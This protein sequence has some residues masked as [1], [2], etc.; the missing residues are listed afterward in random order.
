M[1]NYQQWV[2]ARP[3]R[4]RFR[5]DFFKTRTF[6][7]QKRLTVIFSFRMFFILFKKVINAGAGSKSCSVYRLYNQDYVRPIF[8]KPKPE[9]RFSNNTCVYNTILTRF[10]LLSPE[11]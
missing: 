1:G 7:N 3:W 5:N 4:G 2:V 8:L 9:K 6:C 11:I 10:T